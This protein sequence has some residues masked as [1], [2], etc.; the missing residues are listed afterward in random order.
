MQKG[1]KRGDPDQLIF[2]MTFEVFKSSLQECLFLATP[3]VV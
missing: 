2:S 3:V 1:E